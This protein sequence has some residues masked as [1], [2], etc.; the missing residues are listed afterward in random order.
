VRTAAN[1]GLAVANDVVVDAG[2]GRLLEQKI[3]MHVSASG[4]SPLSAAAENRRGQGSSTPG[5]GNLN[6][7]ARSWPQKIGLGSAPRADDW[8]IEGQSLEARLDAAS[9]SSVLNAAVASG[10]NHVSAYENSCLNSKVDENFF[11]MAGGNLFNTGTSHITMG[12]LELAKENVGEKFIVHGGDEKLHDKQERVR[13][14]SPQNV[15][16]NS[17]ISSETCIDSSMSIKLID[18]SH[19]T[20]PVPTVEQVIAFGGIPKP[21]DGVRSSTRLGNQ[22][23]GDMT[24]IDRAMKRA[25]MRDDPFSSGKQ[26]IPKLS[27]VDI[28]ESDFIHR[29]GSLGISLGKN[30]MEVSES[31]RGIKCLEEKRILIML[32]KNVDENMNKDEGPSTLLMSKVSTLCEDLV[33]D[34][35]I[36]LDFDDPV[37]LLKPAIKGK[38]TRQRKTYDTNNIR[39]STRRRIKKQFS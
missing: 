16:G 8:P 37:E 33:E 7:H 3:H 35:S 12:A 15:K 32:Q 11:F 22:I 28:P 20:V 23:D 10:T 17:S 24:Q 4:A 18:C 39:K 5:R 2:G 29:A 38:K 34:E 1:V 13:I 27:I 9:R 36:P 30:D 26:L 19:D 31:I 6:V 14:A 21:S 25:Q